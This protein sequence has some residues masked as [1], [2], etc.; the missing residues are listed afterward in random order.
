MIIEKE[1]ILWRLK[2]AGIASGGSACIGIYVHGV[3]V[4]IF[5]FEGN[6]CKMDIVWICFNK[7]FTDSIEI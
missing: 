4:L 3:N 6:I 7:T 2:N 1:K 5:H